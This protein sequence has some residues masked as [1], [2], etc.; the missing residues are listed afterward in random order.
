MTGSFSRQIL[1]SLV[2]LNEEPFIENCL[3]SLLEQTVQPR[4]VIFDNASTDRTVEIARKFPVELRQSD[5]NVGYSAAHNQV[6]LSEKAEYCVLLNS[7][8]RLEAD[9]I[10][11]LVELLERRPEVG[12]AGGKLFRMDASGG[13]ASNAEGRILDSAGMYIT[14]VQRHFDR[15]SGEVD[16][17]QYDRRQSVFGMT[18]AAVVYRRAMLEELRFEDEYLDEDFFAYREDADLAWRARIAGWD[19]AYE[20]GAVGRH[21]RFVLPSGRRKLNPRINY[22]SVKNRFLM[23][24]KNMDRAV[25]WKCFPYFYMRDAGILAY[26]LLSERSSLPA[27]KEVWRLRPRTEAKRR[28]I[29]ASRK[30]SPHEIAQWFSFAPVARELE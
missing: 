2:T 25:F 26:M 22:H 18:G 4:I 10:E 6:L 28:A 11:R 29:E 9:F 7:D 3:A 15:G 21:H 5:R 27:L 12:I 16:R 20:P 14:P 13:I 24:A 23:R 19:V 1:V 17:G 30:V 8:L